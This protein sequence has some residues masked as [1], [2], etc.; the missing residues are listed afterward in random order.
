MKETSPAN[1]CLRTARIFSRVIAAGIAGL[2]IMIFV[3]EGIDSELLTSKESVLLVAMFVSVAG[4]L[5]LTVPPYHQ[6]RRLLIGAILNISGVTAFYILN[7]DFSGRWPGGWV[8]PLMA[9][10]GLIE[11]IC[12]TCSTSRATTST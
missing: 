1:I 8:F 6:H 5:L 12:A 10:P 9:V 7:R 2:V 4:L 11:L 3:G